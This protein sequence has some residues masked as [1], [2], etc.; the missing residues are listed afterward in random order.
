MS[1]HE[2]LIFELHSPKLKRSYLAIKDY[3][4]LLIPNFP[5][6]N[7]KDLNKERE[8]EAILGSCNLVMK[9]GRSTPGYAKQLPAGRGECTVEK[10]VENVLIYLVSRMSSFTWS[11]ECPHLLGQHRVGNGHWVPLSNSY[12]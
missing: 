6:G 10:E 5:R 7:N 11:A 4:V 3:S 1:L 12:V 9:V 2:D 8:V